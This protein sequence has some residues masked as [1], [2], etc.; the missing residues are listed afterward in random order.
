MSP[1]M[2]IVIITVNICRLHSSCS[3]GAPGGGGWVA[4]SGHVSDAAVGARR[5]MATAC[6]TIV[7]HTG[8]HTGA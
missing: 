1:I 5:M 6:A 8:W 7:C 4:S 3:P 2:I